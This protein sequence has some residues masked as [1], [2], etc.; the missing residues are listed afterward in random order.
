MRDIIHL[1]QHFTDMP[2]P[3]HL[4][5][6]LWKVIEDH[7]GEFC[8]FCG[9]PLFRSESKD[10]FT[11]FDGETGCWRNF[12]DKPDLPCFSYRARYRPAPKQ[13]EAA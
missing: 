5:G 11:D 9:A 7:D 6:D 4:L 13:R 8:G 10:W 2:D 12:I 1:G 3:E